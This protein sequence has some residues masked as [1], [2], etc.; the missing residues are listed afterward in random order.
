M[1]I[2]LLSEISDNSPP[3]CFMTKNLSQNR[4]DRKPVEEVSS[5]AL[6]AARQAIK[7]LGL[8]ANQSK[9]L[10]RAEAIF[11]AKRKTIQTK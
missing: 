8:A 4:T 5:P 6:I 3:L 2:V 7:E 9:L 10:A 1:K 11:V